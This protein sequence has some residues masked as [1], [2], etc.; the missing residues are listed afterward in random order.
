[1]NYSAHSYQGVTDVRR[2]DRPVERLT[3]AGFDRLISAQ[4][5]DEVVPALDEVERACN[6]GFTAVGFVAYE[7]AGAFDSAL[8][9]HEPR[10]NL[11]LLFF[12]LTRNPVSNAQDAEEVPEVSPFIPDWG[13][14]DYLQRF[15]VVKQHIYDGDTYQINLTFPLRAEFNGSPQVCYEKLRAAQHSD[16]CGMITGPDFSI[17]SASPELFFERRGNRIITR[18]MK[19]TRRRG[20]HREEDQLLAEE[21]QSNEKD[22]AENVMI[23]D[24][25]RNDLGRIAKTGS[26]R[27]PELFAVEK[28]PTVW[29]MTSTVEAEVEDTA[30]LSQIFA[31]L[32]P[33]G[34]VTG[35]PKVKTMEIIRELESGPR[36]VYCGAF[37]VVYPG[38]DCVFNVPIRTMT[39]QNGIAVYPVGSGL[40]ADSEGRDEYAEC[41]VKARVLDRGLSEYQL[42]ETLLWNADGYY[43]LDRHLSRLNRS[44][45]LLGF[46]LNESAVRQALSAAVEDHSEPMRVRL[47]VSED[48][49]YDIEVGRIADFSKPVLTVKLADEPVDSENRFLYHKTTRRAVYNRERE[50]LNGADDA[51]LYNR[52][53][54]LT[55]STIANIALCL[56]GTWVTP[57]V[58]SGLL[59]GVMRE[60]LLANG[61]LKE[62]VLS[63]NDLKSAEGIR[64]MNSVRGVWDVSLQM[65]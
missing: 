54:E 64:L 51:I 60:E 13:V 9:C 26:V 31:G 28:Y 49:H 61:T 40:V 44:S 21:L 22:R 8:E 52:R 47:L 23:V 58:S 2:A 27:V 38:G 7:A 35:A 48:G 30:T 50:R 56:D 3:F 16:Y 5:L 62:R 59:A 46:E 12:G 45:E 36:G 6:D 34:S 41:L 25:L 15:N 57:P 55:E 1:M 19:G 42:L 63:I 11:P 4:C 24:L 43:L 65:P 14:E 39:I 10:G 53:G 32:F 18:P 17:V 37:G 33:C 29:Q 20:R